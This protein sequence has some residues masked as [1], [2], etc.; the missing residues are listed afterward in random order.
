[1]YKG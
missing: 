1:M